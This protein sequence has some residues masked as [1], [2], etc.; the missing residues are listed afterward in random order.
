MGNFG[1]FRII[2]FYINYSTIYN[3]IR[4]NEIPNKNN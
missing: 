1:D 3:P 4:F 2:K